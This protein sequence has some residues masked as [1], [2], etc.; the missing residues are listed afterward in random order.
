[1]KGLEV[2]GV[3]TDY[4]DD[5]GV[6][7][8]DRM[9]AREW[10]ETEDVS[11]LSL[12]LGSGA[13]AEGVR[14]KLKGKY[15]GLAVFTNTHLRGEVMRIFKQTFAITYALEAIGVVVAL[16]G[17]GITL[18]SIL[19][20][21]RAELTTLRALG[22]SRNDIT[23]MA[24]WEGALLA[25]GGTAGGLV[26]SLGLGALLIFVINKQTFGWTLLPAVPGRALFVLGLVVPIAGA[27]V[28]AVV[29]RYSADLPVDRAE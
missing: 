3:Y 6:V 11:T 23:Q 12:V 25:F 16:A 10:F 2:A 14:A 1:M 9:H 28:A 5:Q 13:D 27:L 8:V 21:R 18:A 15:S 29:G 26:T 19:A 20:E 22:M 24:A 7:M 17:L 4:G